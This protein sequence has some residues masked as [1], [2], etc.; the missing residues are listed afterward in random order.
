MLKR[1]RIVASVIILTICL[2]C[3][4]SGFAIKHLLNEWNKLENVSVSLTDEQKLEDFEQFY[5][6]ICERIPFLDDSCEIYGIDFQARKK[7][8][9]E[10]ITSAESNLDFYDGYWARGMQFSYVYPVSP[11]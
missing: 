3:I 1:K 11:I 4:V 9:E 8:Y 2:G 5:S 7:I 6:L 10:T